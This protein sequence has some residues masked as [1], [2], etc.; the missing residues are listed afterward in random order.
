MSETK[1]S[2]GALR[3]AQSLFKRFQEAVN[4][5]PNSPVQTSEMAEIIDREM[6]GPQVEELVALADEWEK[7]TG[8]HDILLKFIAKIRALESA[9]GGKAE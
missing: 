3:A 6:G 1:P 4:D 5:F 7:W 2:A 9:L 8:K